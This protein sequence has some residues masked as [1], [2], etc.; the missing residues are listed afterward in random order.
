MKYERQNVEVSSLQ[1]GDLFELPRQPDTVCRVNYHRLKEDD[2]G[3]RIGLIG[4]DILDGPLRWP[5]IHLPADYPI[6]LL[7]PI[8]T[9]VALGGKDWIKSVMESADEQ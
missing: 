6:T 2:D 7:L 1:D 4:Y 8:T 5:W 3:R 9:F